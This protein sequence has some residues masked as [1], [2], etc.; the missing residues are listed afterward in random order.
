MIEVIDNGVG[1]YE[2]DIVKIFESHNKSKT[3]LNGIGINNTEK[4]IKLNC[5]DEYGIKIE[6]EKYKFTRV[7]LILPIIKDRGND[8]V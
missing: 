1:M 4:R 3:S 7:T 2:K 6:S 5:G 8:Y